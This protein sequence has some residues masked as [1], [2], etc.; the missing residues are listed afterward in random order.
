MK[1]L[2]RI[3]KKLAEV[4]KLYPTEAPLQAISWQPFNGAQ[5]LAYHCPA[6]ELFYGGQ[7][8]GG[9]TDLILGLALTA[10]QRSLIIRRRALDLAA[11]KVRFQELT[12][13]VAHN[14][15]WLN[16]RYI[17]LGGCKDEGT[18]YKY[19]GQPHDGKFFDEV[20]QLLQSQ[21]E[22]IKTWNRTA[23]IGQRC[24]V[25][26]SFNP[27][28]SQEQRWILEYLAPWLNPKHPNPA[29]SGELRYYIGNDE[30][31]SGEAIEVNGKLIT[32][33]SRCFI[34]SSTTDNP[35]LMATGYQRVLD[36]LPAHLKAL[37]NF[38]DSIQD[39]PYQ[40]IPTKWVED[41][42]ARW[43][44]RWGGG[45]MGQVGEMMPMDTIAA[46]PSRG[47]GDEFAL[48]MRH[49]S[50]VFV[51]GYEGKEIPDGIVGAAKVLLHRRG[52]ARIL[53]DVIGV[54]SS[55]FDQLKIQGY[56]PMAYMGS[57]S[58]H[59]RDRT[60][61]FGF[62]NKRA[63][64]Y[65]LLREAL[66]PAYS[67]MLALPDDPKVLAELTAPRWFLSLRGIQVESKDDIRKRLGRSTN[68]ADA[69]VMCCDT[70]LIYTS[71]F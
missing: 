56:E 7:P 71:C 63:E 50:D 69:I 68:Y 48:A 64:S 38:A 67:P 15:N 65:W 10:H 11:I 24:R 23:T 27:P 3:E 13:K 18:K 20:N 47:G 37:T 60:G 5:T 53:I 44:Q 40:V 45:G 4:E 36:N 22:Y 26:S 30:V 61:Q 43:R 8:G 41:A 9:K 32:P 25:V 19:Q 21:Y 39:D 49:Q 42:Q 29:Q 59:R 66:D 51:A 6:D 70:S 1:G 57:H 28:T 33:T 62:A 34:L 31:P 55:T 2:S 54:G 14:E 17:A 58:S 46:D 16:G 35:L 12:G 52:K